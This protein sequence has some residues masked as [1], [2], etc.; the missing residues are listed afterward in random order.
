MNR[1][2]VRERNGEEKKGR[3][4]E[5]KELRNG[6]EEGRIEKRESGQVKEGE[7]K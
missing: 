6:S 2:K 1:E 7:G 5:R 3:E 4:E